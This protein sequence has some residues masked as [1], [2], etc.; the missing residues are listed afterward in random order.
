MDQSPTS[1][2][3][4]FNLSK[5]AP[6]GSTIPIEWYDLPIDV[7]YT[8]PYVTLALLKHEEDAVNQELK[9]VPEI[10]HVSFLNPHIIYLTLVKR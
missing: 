1:P 10:S 7:K 3:P 2:K 9:R 6:D 8:Q 5:L 4:A